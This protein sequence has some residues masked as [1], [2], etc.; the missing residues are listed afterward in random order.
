[1]KHENI[2]VHC[3]FQ[4]AINTNSTGQKAKRRKKLKG[5]RKGH[6]RRRINSK[7]QGKLAR[8][9]GRQRKLSDSLISD[10]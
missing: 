1:M 4:E 5:G 8:E 6:F 2:L 10:L 9:R 3:K 7:G